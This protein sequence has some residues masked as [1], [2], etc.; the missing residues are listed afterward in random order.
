MADELR[1]VARLA[2]DALTGVVGIVQD[3]HRAIARNGLGPVG[4]LQSAM[5]APIYGMVRV[6]LAAGSV[7]AETALRN[8]AQVLPDKVTGVL[9]GAIGDRLVSH[10]PALAT[11]L[12]LHVSEERPLTGHLVVFVHGL[13]HTE[14]HWWQ[15]GPDYGQRLADDVGATPLYVRYNSGQHVA[16]NGARLAVLLD[17]VVAGWPVPV[18]GLSLVGHSMGGLVARSAVHEAIEARLR[19]LDV[20]RNVICLGSPHLGSP[21]ERGAAVAALVLNGFSASAP[22]ARLVAGRSAG[23]KDMGRGV[24]CTAAP[25]ARQRFLAAT[26]AADPTSVGGRIFGDLLVSTASA[27]DRSQA[28]DRDV[29]GG[30]THPALLHHPEVYA[31]LVTWL[32]SS[33]DTASG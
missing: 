18:R 8:S 32:S 14:Q 7:V 30:L 19:W 16:T 31:R 6:G 28:A 26:V 4:D 25:Q 10:Y 21:V 20:L 24:P 2:F 33:A 15:D 23:I 5:A 12:R 1:T 22:L 3:M 9:N 11:P 17:E 13:V 27:T 29:V